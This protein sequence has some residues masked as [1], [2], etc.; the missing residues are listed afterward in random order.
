LLKVKASL[1]A[2]QAGDEIFPYTAV[3]PSGV[4][5]IDAAGTVFNVQN[6]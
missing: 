2:K 4:S 3:L 1:D 5:R 6:E